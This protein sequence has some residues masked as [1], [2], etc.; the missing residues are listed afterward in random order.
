MQI[1]FHSLKGVCDFLR[2][3][4]DLREQAVVQC[5]FDQERRANNVGILGSLMDIVL[6]GSQLPRRDIILGTSVC[7]SASDEVVVLQQCPAVW[8]EGSWDAGFVLG[9]KWEGMGDA[10]GRQNSRSKFCEGITHFN[11]SRVF[12]IEWQRDRECR[13]EVGS[14]YGRSITGE[15]R[16]KVPVVSLKCPV[17]AQSVFDIFKE[18]DDGKYLS[19]KII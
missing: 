19:S 8:T 17:V 6:D 9:G 12:C 7:A 2:V 4:Q 11:D 1:V 5:A 18:N 13:G 3:P 14:D 16:L 15:L 10:R